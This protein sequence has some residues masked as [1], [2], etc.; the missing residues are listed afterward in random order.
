MSS[1][2]L[3]RRQ[4]LRAGTAGVALI[5]LP[6]RPAVACSRPALTHGVQSGDVG[7]RG[8]HVWAR[9]DRPS[10]MMVEVARTPRF[11]HADVVQGPALTAATDF[12]GKVQL[13]E[14][15]PGVETFYRVTL[16]DATSPGVRSEPLTG[17]FRTAPEGRRDVSFTWSGDL[18]GQGWGINPE[19]GGYRIFSA[20]GEL[21]PD[22]FL[23][24]GDTVYADGP[25]SPTVALPAGRTWHNVVTDAKSKVAETLDDF[26]GQF[27]YN[28]L[29]ENLREFAAHVPQINQWDDHE[30]HNNW[31]P[32]QVLTDTRYGERRADVLAARSKQAFFEWLP[33]AARRADAD[34]RIYRRISHGRMLDLFVLDMRTFKDPNGD[35][36]YADPER[37][38]LGGRQRAWL[39][40]ELATSTA[41]WKVLAIDLPLGLVVPDGPAALEGVAQGDG[42]LPRGRELE[43]ADVLSF[44]HRNAISGIVMLTADVHYTA[45]HHYHPARAA[46]GDFDPFWE[47]VSGPLNAGAFGPNT[48]DSTFGPEAVFVAAPPAP[49]TSPADGFQFFGHVAI[50]S[51]SRAMTVSLRDLDGRVLYSVTLDA[52]QHG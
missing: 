34:G 18:A 11:A 40:R 41:T 12:T 23:C 47:F 51:A 35:N 33:I 8:G 1:T 14:L 39:E 28:L 15:P 24:T 16:E 13:T 45:A 19:L 27:A 52:P 6:A 7:A 36:R 38:L 48:L 29:D 32:G 31:Y 3:T 46:V 25:L 50:D 37:G 10:R 22:F 30:V 2:S 9:A 44:A 4:L 43:F 26:R 42:G 17:S 5:A 20:M 21:E 49:N